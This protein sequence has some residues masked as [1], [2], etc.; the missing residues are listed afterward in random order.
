MK[1]LIL[2]ILLFILAVCL[3]GCVSITRHREEHVHS[4]P[5]PDHRRP[6]IIRP[7]HPPLH[8]AHRQMAMRPD[9]R[10]RHP[11]N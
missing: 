3:T 8:N 9:P 4:T 7:T 1:R 6:V 10:E 11:L 2:N 5:S